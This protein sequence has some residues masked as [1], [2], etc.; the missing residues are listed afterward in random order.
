VSTLWIVA[1]AVVPLV[2][3]GLV[4]LVAA[5]VYTAVTYG[6][7]V[8]DRREAGALSPKPAAAELAR[9][10]RVFLDE[11]FA[12]TCLF[13]V[14]PIGSIDPPPPRKIE[15]D[16]RRPI[17]LVPGYTQMQS[18]LW[19][20]SA[21]LWAAGLGP[22]YTINLKPWDASVV[23]HAK[24]LSAYVDELLLATGAEQIDV[25]AHSMGGIVARL[26]EAG[27]I[28]PRI[29]RLVTIGT[30][31]RGTRVAELAT[32]QGGIDLRVRS[33][34]LASLPPPAPGMIVAISSEHDNVIVPPENARIGERGRDVIV[35]GVGH[36][37]MLL[38][39]NVATEVAKALGEDVRTAEK[40]LAPLPRKHAVIG[41]AVRA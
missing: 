1:I 20:L 29:R 36:L 19:L 2:L 31:H 40:V 27:R 16:G 39:A 14:H 21:R 32:G 17:L 15:P 3:A 7:W 18:N 34:V 13:F 11:L 35:E 24:A 10:V 41:G 8:V 33:A 6:V 4:A 38:D 22:T 30:P 25:V 9:F 37:A 23:E 26:A 5:L 28:T 12:S